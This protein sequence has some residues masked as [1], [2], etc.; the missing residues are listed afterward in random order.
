MGADI[1]AVV[2]DVATAVLT[3][4]GNL[5][6]GAILLIYDGTDVT[7]LGYMLMLVIGAPLAFGVIS[8]IFNQFKKIKIFSGSR[9]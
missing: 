2:F 3:G 5:L 6:E 8:W 4:L 1:V 7:N 9:R